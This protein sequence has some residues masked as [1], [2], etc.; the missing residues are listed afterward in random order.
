MYNLEVEDWHTYYVMDEGVLVHNM[1]MAEPI[2]VAANKDKLISASDDITIK[3][4]NGNLKRAKNY[5]GRLDPGMPVTHEDII[6]GIKQPGGD[7]FPPAT[8]IK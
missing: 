3:A 5:H 6:L 8:Q 1:C 7:S 4:Q 2:D